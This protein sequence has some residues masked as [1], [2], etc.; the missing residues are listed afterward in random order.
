LLGSL[1]IVAL[2]PRRRLL[3]AAMLLSRLV[4]TGIEVSTPS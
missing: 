2:C 3:T 4:D 1:D